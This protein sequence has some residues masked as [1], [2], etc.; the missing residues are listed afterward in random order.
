MIAD[1]FSQAIASFVGTACFG[2]IF[3]I[4]KRSLVQCGLAGMVGWLVYYGL[5]Q[6]DAD[7]IAATWASAVLIGLIAHYLAIRFKVP[8]TVFSVSG[9][10]PLVPGGMAYDAMLRVVQ[11]DYMSAVELGAKAFMLSGAIAVGLVFSE[12]VNQLVKKVRM[13]IARA[14]G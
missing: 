4:P 11:N 9:I 1:Y 5:I 7:P 2:V 6:A 8:V 14:G 12:V 10:I 13:G 3:Q